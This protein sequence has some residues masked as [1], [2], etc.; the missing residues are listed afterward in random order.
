MET[1]NGRYVRRLSTLVLGLQFLVLSPAVAQGLCAGGGEFGPE[2]VVEREALVTQAERQLD[3]VQ[4]RHAVGRATELELLQS[5]I[6]LAEARVHH[7]KI[8]ER[9]PD[10]HAELEAIVAARQRQFEAVEE[11]FR[12]GGRTG[13]EVN[14][15]QIALSEALIRLQRHRILQAYAEIL[16]ATQRRYETGN[17]T[18]DELRAA[19]AAV[20]V[21]RMRFCV[22]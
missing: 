19:E 21:A 9:H 10:L 12:F 22:Q 16:E 20:E 1:K 17:A 13:T 5:R 15:V 4:E 2:D 7:M 18:A 6:G 8:V 11:S 14:T 3:S